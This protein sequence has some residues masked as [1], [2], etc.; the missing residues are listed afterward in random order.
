MAIHFEELWEK[1][2]K[3]HQDIG[4][5]DPVSAILDELALKIDLYKMI[6]S[7]TEVSAEERLKAKSRTMGEILLTLTDLSLKDN[8]NV[9]ESL[10]VAQQY[11]R[12]ELN[13]KLRP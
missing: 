8:I 13:K 11:R 9:F 7:K 4:H 3:L 5:N 12:L 1:C 10:S 2:E 6:D